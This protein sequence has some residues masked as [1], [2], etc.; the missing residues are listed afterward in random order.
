MKI[1]VSF[2]NTSRDIKLFLIAKNKE[3]ISGFIK[4]A[5]EYYINHLEKGIDKDVCSR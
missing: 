1:E 4:D 5:I 2:K 3:E